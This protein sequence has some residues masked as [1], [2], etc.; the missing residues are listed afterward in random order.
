MVGH[1]AATELRTKHLYDRFELYRIHN[2]SLIL[3]A[4]VPHDFLMTE[5]AGALKKLTGGDLNVAEKKSSNA[6][7]AFKGKLNVLITSNAKLVLRLFSDAGA[8]K[9]RLII[10]DFPTARPV[11]Q[12]IDNYAEKLV[13]EEGPG[14]LNWMI[15]GAQQL[16]LDIAEGRNFVLTAEQRARVEERIEESDSLATF[17][18]DYICKDDSR[19]AT[20]DILIRYRDYCVKRKWGHPGEEVITRRLAE[21]LPHMF[22]AAPSKHVGSIGLGDLRG[23]TGINWQNAFEAAVQD[24]PSVASSN[25]ALAALMKMRSRS[26]FN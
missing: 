24:M 2:K 23:Y 11:E 14:I 20:N 18:K 16:L 15:A 10:I 5:G 22:G 6:E 9:R 12:N 4:D 13:A 3:G 26:S 8:W 21:L 19:L 25:G 1:Q 17:C 7:F